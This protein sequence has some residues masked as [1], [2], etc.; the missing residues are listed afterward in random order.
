MSHISI[1]IPVKNEQ[2]KLLRC[3]RSIQSGCSHYIYFII[4]DDQSTDLTL[5]IANQALSSGLFEGKV[6][7]NEGSS[8]VGAGACR[9]LGI[10]HLL[11]NTE[12]VL[13]YDADDV[14]PEGVLSR[15]ITQTEQDQADVS[16]AQYDYYISNT[17][18]IGMNKSDLSIW[19]DLSPSLI[20]PCSYE[21]RSQLLSL[22]NYPWNKLLRYQFIKRIGLR[23]STTPVHNDIYAHWVI[24]L[25]AESIS[26][27][28]ESV[29]HH[30]VIAGTQQITNVFD[31]KRLALIVVLDEVQ[32]YF[33]AYQASFQFYYPTFLSFKK[34]V[35]SWAY[36]RIRADIKP[37]FA[38]LIQESY[39]DITSK[40][41]LETSMRDPSAAL[42]SG[43]LKLGMDY[44][45]LDHSN[46]V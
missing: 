20:K 1:I 21:Q 2:D 33:Y 37:H 42:Q 25:N 43:Q 3:I 39:Q 12:Y 29:C 26:L 6:L 46:H 45:T 41:V 31:E 11:D 16:I 36:Q 30:F 10:E 7:L 5:S 22:I 18:S 13:F 38:Q 44:E 40:I 14:M 17:V 28:P 9:N 24:L 27:F 23:F 34:A 15:W 35:L 19:Q 8:G 4:V 32:A